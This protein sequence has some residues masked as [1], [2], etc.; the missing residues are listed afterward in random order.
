MKIILDHIERAKGKPHHI[1]KQIAFSAAGGIAAFIAL[2]WLAGSLASGTFAIQG[3]SF[4]ESTRQEESVIVSRTEN[5]NL[6]GVA[7]TIQ[8]ASAPAH[9]E[10]IDTTPVAPKAKR[11][12]QTTLP[13]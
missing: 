8:D 7:A 3:S 10:I 5:P 2:V 1:R 6:A 13:F 11:V 9:I 4:V 12:E